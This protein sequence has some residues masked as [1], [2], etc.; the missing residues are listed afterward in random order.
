MA[1]KSKS[2]TSAGQLTKFNSDYVTLISIN[3]LKSNIQFDSDTPKDQI[4]GHQMKMGKE[5]DYN[6]E[7]KMCRVKLLLEFD[8]ID[9]NDEVDERAKAVF[10]I[11]FHFKVDNMHD[12]I[13]QADEVVKID[14]TMPAHLV[15][16]AYSTARGIVS[17]R[18]GNTP[19][20][21]LIL[22]IINPYEVLKKQ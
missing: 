10:T 2:K 14:P 8:G 21:G 18:L 3:V 4:I 17:E 20:Q 13:E 1:T 11:D 6:F 12:C 7:A 16:I 15:G 22:P 5:I 19:F 9:S